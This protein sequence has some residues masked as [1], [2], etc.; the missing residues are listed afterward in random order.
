MSRYARFKVF[1]IVYGVAYMGLF[2]Q[3]E[4]TKVAMFRYYP[5]LGTFSREALQTFLQF[6]TS[7]FGLSWEEI[8]GN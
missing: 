1:S 7:Q 4:F 8:Q 6:A 3:S 5:V 2:L